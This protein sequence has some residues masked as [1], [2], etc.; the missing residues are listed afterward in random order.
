MLLIENK[1]MRMRYSLLSLE[2][3]KQ[4]NKD[5]IIDKYYQEIMKVCEK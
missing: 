3:A 4:F 1:G 5:I 2:R